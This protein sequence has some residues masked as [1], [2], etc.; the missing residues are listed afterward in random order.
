MSGCIIN[1]QRLIQMDHRNEESRDSSSLDRNF[2]IHTNTE[3]ENELQIPAWDEGSSDTYTHV[4]EEL[5]IYKNK[6][7]H[8]ENHLEEN[9]REFRELNEINV[10]L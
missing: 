8:L 5:R 10:R 4:I 3:G 2:Q 9:M 6:C 1:S 7:R